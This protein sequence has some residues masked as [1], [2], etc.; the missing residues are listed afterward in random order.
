[1]IIY[2]KTTLPSGYYVYAYVRSDGK[3]YYICKGIGS[4]AW[5]HRKRERIHQPTDHSRIIICESN[6]SEIGALALERKLIRIWG[7]KDLGE[8]ILQNR[9][10]GGEGVSSGERH[11]NYGKKFTNT[12]RNKGNSSIAGSIAKRGESN[13]M[14]N[15]KHKDSTKKILSDIHMGKV[16]KKEICKHCGKIVS[17]GNFK[18][19]HD[20][21]CKFKTK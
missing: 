2:S 8:G 20:V 15:K 7:R 3:P 12:V 9:S 11:P 10:D 16:W 6:L 13:P 14:F 4:R 1:M 17:I 19:W 5:S 21:N 18:R